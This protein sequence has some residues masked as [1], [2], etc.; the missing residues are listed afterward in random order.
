MAGLLRRRF[1]D[2][3]KIDDDSMACLGDLLELWPNG[4]WRRS[5]VSDGWLMKYIENDFSVSTM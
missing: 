1:F 5:A 4:D 3:E 2:D